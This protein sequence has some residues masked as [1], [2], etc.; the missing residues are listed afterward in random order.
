EVEVFEAGHV[1]FANEMISKGLLSPSAH[2]QLCLGINWCMP[3]SA[4]A[5]DFLVALLPPEATWSAFG[6]GRYQFPMVEAAIERGGHARIGL[7]D[8]L[9][10]EAGVFASSNAA[11]VEKAAS[12]ASLAGRPPASAMEAR[13]ILGLDQNFGG[14]PVASTQ[15]DIESV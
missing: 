8:N 2:F 9:Y 3:A 11:L 15:P 7:E 5:M 13:T 6:I 12:I 14:R 10:L 4:K 1:A